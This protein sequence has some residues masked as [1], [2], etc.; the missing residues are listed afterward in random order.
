M[1]NWLLWGH[2]G[3]HS[4]QEDS[5]AQLPE[6]GLVPAS[7]A[8]A[9]YDHGIPNP[10]MAWPS[11][12]LPNLDRCSSNQTKSQTSS[13]FH[14]IHDEHR[15]DAA[16]SSP[17]S[18]MR[19]RHS[20]NLRCLSFTVKQMQTHMKNMSR[21]QMA[22]DLHLDFGRIFGLHKIWVWPQGITCDLNR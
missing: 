17:Q 10:H 12:Q 9:S 3:H 7:S 1:S 22:K 21:V 4:C 14:Q 11:M 2:H 16:I 8:L 15:P 13:M 19:T 5:F 20:R 18:N 6:A